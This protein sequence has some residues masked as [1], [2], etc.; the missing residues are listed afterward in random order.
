MWGWYACPFG[1]AIQSLHGWPSNA[2]CLEEEPNNGDI[3]AYINWMLQTNDQLKDFNKETQDTIMV[4][5]KDGAKGMYVLFS[6]FET[7]YI[8]IG[9]CCRF[10]WV[11]LQ[12]DEL[13]NCPNQEEVEKQLRSLPEDLDGVYEQILM[14]VNKR[15]CE[16]TKK[17]LEWCAFAA[18]PLR[19]EEL[20]AVA[21]IDFNL[22]GGIHNPKRQYKNQDTL[23]VACSSLVTNSKGTI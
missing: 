2:I 7:L 20:A 13:Q 16:D 8:N 14:K 1:E 18:R 5:L 21:A 6:I 19:L 22:E 4:A 10:R 3:E 12:L 11:A 9:T 23:L 17:L 15:S